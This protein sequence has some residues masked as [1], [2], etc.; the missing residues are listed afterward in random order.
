M[1]GDPDPTGRFSWSL[2]PAFEKPHKD[3]LVGIWTVL[4]GYSHLSKWLWVKKGYP[5]GTLVNGNM[6]DSTC[7]PIPGA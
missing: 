2:W 5:N 6:D 7:G 3:P 4:S 1:L